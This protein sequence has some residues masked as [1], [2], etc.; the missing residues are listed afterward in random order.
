MELPSENS[1]PVVLVTGGAK[2]IGAALCRA[3]SG[4]GWRVVIHCRHSLAEAEG[5]S[6]ELGGKE[7]ACVIQADLLQVGADELI[8]R[9]AACFGRL[10]ALVNNASC[11]VRREL[12]AQSDDEVHNDFECNFL[13]PFALM[14][15]FAR[16]GV[17]GQ[18]LNILDGKIALH[19]SSCI[20]YLLAKKSLA[21]ATTA[22]ALA[23]GSLGIRVNGLAP[24]LVRP[25]E[26][27]PIEAMTKLVS[28]TPL[29]NR[30]TEEEI[31]AAAL[32]LTG[33][34]NVTGTILY[35]DGGLHLP[36]VQLGERTLN[37]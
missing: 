14:R 16:R 29:G 31:A 9:V 27:V 6:R 19:D 8:S 1:A 37:A 30:T 24:G 35:V 21:E 23:W 20:G 3:F 13:V 22:C 10:D 36:E 4:A 26:G 12:L 17:P 25:K 7:H 15:A 5:L 11:Y 33:A 34:S 18:I 32:Y 2:R 28:R